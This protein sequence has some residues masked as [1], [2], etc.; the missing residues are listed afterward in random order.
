MP[1]FDPFEYLPMPPA[2]KKK[3]HEETSREAEA[4]VPDGLAPDCLVPA[5]QFSANTLVALRE[6]QRI[7]DLPFPHP[8]DKSY[9]DVLRAKTAVVSAQLNAQLKVSDLDLKREAARVDLWKEIRARMIEFAA[10]RGVV[11]NPPGGDE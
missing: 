7:L 10:K 6:A 2:Q 11:L 8:A 3:N 1:D 5:D 9:G 4:P